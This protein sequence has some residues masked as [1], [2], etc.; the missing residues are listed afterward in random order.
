VDQKTMGQLYLTHDLNAVP[1]F[2]GMGPE[3]FDISFDEFRARLKSYRGEIKGV[4]TRG[5]F[6]AGIGNAY[7][8][9]ILWH[10]RLHPY[11][12][13][14]QLTTEEIAR[15]YDAMQSALHDAVDQVRA[16]MGER[17][18]LKPRD[19][20]AVHLKTGAPCP[21]CGAPISIVSAN[22]R[23]TNFCR[24]CQPGGLIKGM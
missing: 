7:A 17:I 1:D 18:H 22:Q 2:A 4:L 11:R 14:T 20:L 8:D 3:P 9:E 6:V 10:A 13:R 16:E 12:K 5:E 15:L 24:T 23:I 19:F 21:R